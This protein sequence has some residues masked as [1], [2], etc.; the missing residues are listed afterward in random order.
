[1]EAKIIKF[2][3]LFSRSHTGQAFRE[4]TGQRRLQAQ[5]HDLSISKHAWAGL[6]SNGATLYLLPGKE[7]LSKEA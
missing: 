7:K 5:L 1:M 3:R 6:L 4:V 2:P